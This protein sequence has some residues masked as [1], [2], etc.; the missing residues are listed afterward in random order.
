MY[1]D[2]PQGYQITQHHNPIMIDGR[3]F[4]YNH[5]DAEA[6]VLIKLVQM[7]QEQAKIVK[8][9]NKFILDYNYAGVPL[10]QISTEP[11]HINPHDCK[12]VV[13]EMQDLLST[14]GV[15]QARFDNDYMR[16][17]CFLSVNDTLSKHK[18]PTVQIIN[19]DNT[20][21]V[22]RAIEYE[23]RRLVSLLEVGEEIEDEIRQYMPESGATKLIRSAPQFPDYRYFQDP[24][25]PRI[26]IT[27]QRISD[28]HKN[29]REVPFE[30]KRRFCNTFGMDVADVKVMFHHP[31]SL[32]LFSRIVWTLQIDPKVAFT[33][34]Y[35][36]ILEQ[37]VSEKKDFKEILLQAFGPQK[38]IALLEMYQN[39]SISTHNG[40][41]IINLIVN[42]DTRTP[43]E[44]A[45]DLGYIGQVEIKEGL[46]KTVEE[47]VKSQP[48]L[49]A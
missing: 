7:K 16:V 27:N 36:T 40:K 21:S 15:S 14:L 35:K 48:A 32:E 28:A 9:E 26:N 25:L 5:Q 38:L 17:D 49:V 22:E 43:Y 45:S 11:S 18:S 41:T 39:Q 34:I 4:Y 44:I 8:K 10:L 29:I 6:H 19:L 13:E 33:W 47:V 23:Y 30:F 24:D 12:L 42:G 46:I 37:T 3:L 31:W 20:V 2:S 1:P